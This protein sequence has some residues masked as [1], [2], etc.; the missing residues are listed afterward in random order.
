MSP[1]PTDLLILEV[2]ALWLVPFGLGKKRS[3]TT[4]IVMDAGAEG[5]IIGRN[6]WGRPLREAKR[7]TDLVAEVMKEQRYDRKLEEPRFTSDYS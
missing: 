6:F 7:L 5:R 1:P 3:K 4:R 2:V